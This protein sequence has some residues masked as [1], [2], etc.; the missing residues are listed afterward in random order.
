[1]QTTVP[2]VIQLETRDRYLRERLQPLADRDAV[3][4]SEPAREASAPPLEQQHLA[5]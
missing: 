2:T 1:M 4:A 3:Q 5:A